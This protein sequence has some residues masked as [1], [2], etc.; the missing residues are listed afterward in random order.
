MTVNL[1]LIFHES[2]SAFREKKNIPFIKIL[3]RLHVIRCTDHKALYKKRFVKMLA[4]C[5]FLAF[6]TLKKKK[7]KIN[8]RKLLIFLYQL[9]NETLKMSDE[10]LIFDAQFFSTYL[11]RYENSFKKKL[12]KSIF[13]SRTETVTLLF[14]E[15]KCIFFFFSMLMKRLKI[16]C[17]FLKIR[18]SAK[19]RIVLLSH[20]IIVY[21]NLIRSNF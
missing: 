12:L 14:F 21:R 18:K 2:N 10:Y 6:I 17:R 3:K 15:F 7:K 1:F 13:V 4:K 19:C 16:K 5:D 9:K 11:L 20:D 8:N